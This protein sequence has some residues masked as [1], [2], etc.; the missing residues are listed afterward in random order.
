MR[1]SRRDAKLLLILLG[2]VAFLLSYLLVYNRYI[3]KRDAVTAQ[4]AELQPQLD[5]LEQYY[6]N[7]S[8]YEDAIAT[9]KTE[10]GEELD[11]YP[12]EIFTED[13]ILYA[14]ELEDRVG[15]DATAL[16]F[17]DPVLVNE[18][19]GAAD[20]DGTVTTTMM[21]A[22]ETAMNVSCDLSYS[23]LKS[24]LRYIYS[25]RDYTAVNAVNVSYNAES[26]RLLGNLEVAKFFLT[27][28]GATPESHAMP[29]VQKG[30]TALF[31]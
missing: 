6:V 3:E 5:T 7:L 29:Y 30:Q 13:L 25:T 24:V 22:Y 26:G 8:T 16:S 18:F 17:T 21:D 27:Y 15:L 2:I 14:M 31:G 28:D 10:I 4:I 12:S 19:M 1:V 20:Q 23:Q 11:R 9:A